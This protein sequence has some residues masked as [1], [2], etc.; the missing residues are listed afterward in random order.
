MGEATFNSWTRMISSIDTCYDVK[1]CGCHLVGFHDILDFY[2][3]ELHNKAHVALGKCIVK[4][5]QK[6]YWKSDLPWS[7]HG[8][9]KVH[10]CWFLKWTHRSSHLCSL[11]SVKQYS[12]HIEIDNQIGH[13]IFVFWRP[14]A[15]GICSTPNSEGRLDPG[16]VFHKVRP[17]ITSCTIPC[18]SQVGKNH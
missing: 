15:L 7:S 16:G 9:W 8:Y 2:Q 11:L 4:H 10:V 1:V 13:T 5:M 14:F 17:D 3:L 18:A 6:P 12:I